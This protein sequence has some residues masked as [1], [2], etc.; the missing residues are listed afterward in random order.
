[1]SSKLNKKH[2]MVYIKHRANH[3]RGGRFTRVSKQFLIDLEA[4]MEMLIDEAIR[5]H[6]SVGKTLDEFRA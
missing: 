1:M 4:R 6:P 5:Q 3:L 2:T